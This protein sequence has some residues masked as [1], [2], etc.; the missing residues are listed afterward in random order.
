MSYTLLN[1]SQTNDTKSDVQVCEGVS[2]PVVI[3]VSIDNKRDNYLLDYDTTPTKP[4]KR[5]S[6][7]IVW[8][9]SI[10]GALVLNIILI[11]HTVLNILPVGFQPL[12]GYIMALT[13][14]TTSVVIIN[15]YY[16]C[17]NQLNANLYHNARKG[18]GTLFKSIIV[19]GD[20]AI[21]KPCNALMAIIIAYGLT[22]T[23]VLVIKTRNVTQICG[24]T[25]SHIETYG[26]LAPD[27]QSLDFKI[28]FLQ[29]KV[30]W[31]ES[32]LNIQPG[33]F[34]SLATSAVPHTSAFVEYVVLPVVFEA[35]SG[36]LYFD[37][38]THAEWLMDMV[39]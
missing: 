29:F 4:W 27:C 25:V 24:E 36:A 14:N 33:Y 32:K 21:Y 17:R 8:Y 18:P 13:W 20:C 26:S 38:P 39:L 9:L 12:I 6:M 23:A 10:H 28:A 7:S 19:A 31:I 16:F 30:M 11:W 22:L 1:I 37:A 3:N 15:R 35:T 5:I 2:T 34:K